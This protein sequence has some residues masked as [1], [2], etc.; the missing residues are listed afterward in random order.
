[1]KI[2]D[3]IRLSELTNA[4]EIKKATLLCYYYFKELEQKEFSLSDIVNILD[5]NSFS[6]PNASRL[7]KNLTSGRGHPMVINK[8]TD[9][10]TF[11]STTLQALDEGFAKFWENTEEVDSNSELLDEKKFCG[12][13]GYLTKLVE[14]INCSYAH[15]CYDAVAVLLRRLMEILLILSFRNCGKEAEIKTLDN[16]YLPLNN[17]IDKSVGTLDLNAVKGKQKFDSIRNIGNFSA[18]K[19]SYNATRKDIDDIKL[20]YRVLIEELYYKAGI[21]K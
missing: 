18:H 12:H 6:R 21:L 13:R 1:M 17:I 14:Q 8:K 10:L 16:G 11:S 3:F 20:D 4:S 9:K 19:E 7:K 5:N 2:L 15:N